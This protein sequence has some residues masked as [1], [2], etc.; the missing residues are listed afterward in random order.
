[1]K[2]KTRHHL[3]SMSGITARLLILMSR[4]TPEPADLVVAASFGIVEML[5]VK[6]YWKILGPA[7]KAQLREQL[8]LRKGK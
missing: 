5:G 6:R 2:V 4:V 1:M 8:K 7:L 3:F